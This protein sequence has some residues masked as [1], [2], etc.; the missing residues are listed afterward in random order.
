MQ[1]YLRIHSKFISGYP[2][3]SALAVETKEVG[4][5]SWQVVDLYCLRT[6]LARP[7][8]REDMWSL[9]RDLQRRGYILLATCPR[10]RSATAAERSL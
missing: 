4:S 5:S 7:E 9:V 8:A 2:G 6:W 10:R 3:F 1:G